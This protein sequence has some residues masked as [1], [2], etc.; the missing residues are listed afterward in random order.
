LWRAYR[1]ANGFALLL[2]LMA[3]CGSVKNT[4]DDQPPSR[5]RDMAV[6]IDP[7]GGPGGGVGPDMAPYNAGDF[8]TVPSTL[9]IAP[10]SV[11][12]AYGR[13]QL[14]TAN[15]P[16]TW[17]VAEQGGGQITADGHYT[18][19]SASGIFH[20][21]ALASDGSGD[22]I[23]ATV[24]VYAHALTLVAGN[25][26]GSGDADGIGNAARF[27]IG[28]GMAY[29]GARYLYLADAGCV[30]RLDVTTNAVTTVAGRSRHWNGSV[31]DVGPKAKFCLTW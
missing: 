31:D 11:D 26:G 20:V 27:F 13:S 4:I 23:F 30:R 17:S 16:V 5:S 21:E 15:R 22:H 9:T 25:Y 29:D 3:G 8:A 28:R 12:L 6:V 24:N 2:S 10:L 18:A 7:D 14:F 19:P 1:G